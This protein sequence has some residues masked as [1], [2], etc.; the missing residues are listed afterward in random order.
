MISHKRYHALILAAGLLLAAC[1]GT[2]DGKAT[3]PVTITVGG[4]SSA[5]NA[6]AFEAGARKAFF[7]ADARVSSVRTIVF[8]IT[9]PGMEALSR[10][11]AYSPELTVSEVFDVPNGI[12]RHFV[13]EAGDASGIVQYRGSAT[14]PLTGDEVTIAIL[15]MPTFFMGTVQ[16]GTPN[17]DAASGIATDADGNLYIAGTTGGIMDG[18]N[19]GHDDVF[20]TKYDKTGLWQWSRQ[21]GTAGYETSYGIAVDSSRD[22]YVTGGTT[23]SLDGNASAGG[24]DAFVVKYNAAGDKLWTKQTGTTGFEVGTAIAVDNA[25]SVYIAGYTDGKLDSAGSKGGYD[26]FVQK[27]DS[28]TGAVLWTKQL[29]AA[30]DEYAFGLAAGGSGDLYVTGYTDG[31]M[32]GSGNKGGF[33]MFAEKLAS[34]TGTAIWTTQTGSPDDDEPTAAIV[35]SSG[36]LFI[37][38]VTYGS[39]GDDANPDKTGFTNDVFAASYDSA[40]RQAWLQQFGTA[41]ND[42]ALGIGL[43][44]SG[45]VIVTGYTNG[46]LN[47]TNA[48]LSDL[49]AV[50]LDPSST[51]PVWKQQLGTSADDHATGIAIDAAGNAFI[52]GF[53]GSGLDGNTAVGGNDLLL[54]MYD[55][56]GVKQ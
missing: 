36:N 21:L 35:D 41:S 30:G 22:V 56:S 24:T 37:T 28:S 23:G 50:K 20:V 34:S 26:A 48:G 49:F 33:D 43:D 46:D 7:S 45:K 6:A 5:R 42:V 38:G 13:V 40:G 14:G 2:N 53:T 17:D 8:T 1:S 29:G 47:G 32:G 10:T 27:L 31:D 25:G 16:S 9:G 18:A 4:N 51:T 12:D 39:L 15:M 11:V 3:S 54:V 44:P 55:A 52:T 19:A